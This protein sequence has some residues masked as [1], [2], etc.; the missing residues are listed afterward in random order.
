MPLTRRTRPASGPH[1]HPA[2]PPAPD[3]GG[4]VGGCPELPS[5]AAYPP[6]RARECH[7]D[8]SGRSPCASRCCPRSRRSRT[9]CSGSVRATARGSSGMAARPRAAPPGMCSTSWARWT[10]RPAGRRPAPCSA[11]VAWRAGAETPR[12]GA[13]GRDGRERSTL[14]VRPERAEASDRALGVRTRGLL[15]H[16]EHAPVATRCSRARRCR[17][18]MRTASL[19]RARSQKRSSGTVVLLRTYHEGPESD[20]ALGGGVP[21]PRSEPDE[22]LDERP[23][24]I[25][26]AACPP[27]RAREC[28]GGPYAEAP[29][30]PA[31]SRSARPENPKGG[32]LPRE[33]LQRCLAGRRVGCG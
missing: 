21:L 18:R 4:R 28:P 31:T 9:S 5:R 13:E 20:V 33:V 8:S 17:D 10:S 1:P 19:R 24:A 25:R 26:R 7:G 30:S 23:R 3:P 6:P 32:R 29:R 11:T 14:F 22:L 15:R 27:P 16:V 2:P 12:I